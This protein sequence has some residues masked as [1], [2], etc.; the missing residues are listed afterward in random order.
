MGGHRIEAWCLTVGM[1][2]TAEDVYALAPYARTLGVRFTDLSGP[3]VLAELT[4]HS[5]LSTVGGG[6][7]GGALMG[8]ADVAAAVCAVV[9]A[10]PGSTPATTTSA[11]QFLRPVRSDALARAL[12]LHAGRSGA[13]VQVDIT[14]TSDQLCVRVTQTVVVR[15]GRAEDGRAAP[16]PKLELPSR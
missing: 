6:L 8:L 4:F 5:S 13:V 1:P 15:S 10:V 7:H 12:V 9:N 16:S 14:D 3:E 11:T 2:I